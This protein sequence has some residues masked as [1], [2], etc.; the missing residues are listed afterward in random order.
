M[1]TKTAKL[2]FAILN[3]N[4]NEG[5]D[6]NKIASPT[7]A[8]APPPAANSHDANNKSIRRSSIDDGRSLATR[9]SG[10]PLQKSSQSVL[11]IKVHLNRIKLIILEEALKAATST[12]N[13]TSDTKYEPFSDFGIDK[14]TFDY[15]KKNTGSWNATLKITG[16]NL[17]D[18]RK[19][20]NLAVKKMFVPLQRDELIYVNYRVDRS[21]NASLKF[22]LDALRVNLCLPY[23]LKLYAMVMEALST[24][25][26]Q[27][28][29]PKPKNK[30]LKP[31]EESVPV[32]AQSTRLKVE[33]DLNFPQIILFAEP[34]KGDSKVLLM[35]TKIDLKYRAMGERTELALRLNGLTMRL[36][37][38][39]KPNVKG[40]E[41]LAPC[42]IAIGMSQT[43]EANTPVYKVTVACL[44]LFLTP[45]LYKVFFCFLLSRIISR[46]FT[47]FG[48]FFA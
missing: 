15:D 27:P 17:D 45:T 30:A 36:G 7:P 26:S 29:P 5:I 2:L 4:L 23:I 33:G 38:F 13:L 25:D 44:S 14:I 9:H 39:S 41:F 22:V 43:K 34:E 20:S 12:L 46:F 35:S 42:D 8:P 24:A 40:V 16:L 48:E 47:I 10:D 1:S 3:E 18:I 37:E 6:P 32:A 11:Q 31:M 21:G 28:A 19:L